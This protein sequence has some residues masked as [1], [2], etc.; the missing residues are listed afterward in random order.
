MQGSKDEIRQDSGQQR[1]VPELESNAS[2]CGCQRIK[3]KVQGSTQ[4]SFENLDKDARQQRHDGK[5]LQ[6]LSC[7]HA[8]ILDP[9]GQECV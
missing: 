7:T 1:R 2:C 9:D 5:T 8:E 6:R 4:T 3:Q